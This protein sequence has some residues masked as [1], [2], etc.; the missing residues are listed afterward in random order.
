MAMAATTMGLFN[1]AQIEHLQYELFQNCKATR[2]LFE[3]VQDFSQNFV[4]LQN[5]LYELRGM[6]F[7]LILANPKLLDARLSQIE[8]QL[9]LCYSRHP[10]RCPSEVRH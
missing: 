10:G 6:L 9:R 8:N 2:R 5:S 4:G 7:Q 3:V 1:R